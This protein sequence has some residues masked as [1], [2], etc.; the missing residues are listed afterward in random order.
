MATLPSK[1]ALPSVNVIQYVT[2]G[3]KAGLSS[4]FLSHSWLLI[5]LSQH[6]LP[7]GWWAAQNEQH[8]LGV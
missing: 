5:V 3:G 4:F 8:W 1:A 6:I 2:F 7:L